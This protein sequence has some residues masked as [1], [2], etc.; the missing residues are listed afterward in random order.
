MFKKPKSV[1]R[2]VLKK[3]WEVTWQNKFLW[4][5]GLFAALAGN[6]GIYEILV[7]SFEKVV[8]RGEF[9]LQKTPW[10]WEVS[11]LTWPRLEDVYEKS[12]L[13]VNLFWVLF[14]VILITVAVIIWLSITS[15]AALI[16]CIKKIV[17][18][19]K[20]D[21]KE[22]WA[23]GIKFFW[24]VFGLN[25]VAKALIFGLLVLITIPTMFFI[26]GGGSSLG[27]NIVLYILAFVIFTIL[28][29]LISFMTIYASCFVVI[30]NL[31]FVEA[32]RASWRLLIKNWL[33][34]IE[35]AFILFLITLGIGAGLILLSIFYLLPVILLLATFT[36]LE[37]NIGFWIIF[38]LAT[39]GW[40]GGILWVGAVLSTFQFS[41]WTILFLELNKKKI[42]SKILRF[43]GLV[44]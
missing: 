41:T 38:L 6:G 14:F 43:I 27:W 26:T 32:I 42:G 3:A 17:S 13:F 31:P 8:S 21:I 19:R 18:K 4:I 29:L 20:T 1:Y 33:V 2:P 23:N 11:I 40:L 12:P 15:R 9:F 35:V 28:A 10:F 44:K 7:K 16:H 39:L 34:S 5:F 22:G 30:S 36:Y 25:I 24:P 37:L